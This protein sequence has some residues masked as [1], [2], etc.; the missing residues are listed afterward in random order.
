MAEISSMCMDPRSLT[1]TKLKFGK[2]LRPV[3]TLENVQSYFVISLRFSVFFR[4]KNTENGK[5]KTRLDAF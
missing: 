4:H 1:L 2:N 5:A 3:S